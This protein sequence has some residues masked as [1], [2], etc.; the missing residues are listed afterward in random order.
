M[1]KVDGR[2]VRRTFTVQERFCP[3]CPRGPDRSVEN[4]CIYRQPDERLEARPFENRRYTRQAY[5]SDEELVERLAQVLEESGE[6]IAAQF[7]R[8]GAPVS[9]HL[10]RMR[11]G[12]MEQARRAAEERL[13]QRGERLEEVK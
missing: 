13:K 7:Q 12:G 6:L 4:G 10:I 5:V 8:R 11:L 9:Y 2:L 1:V 3:Q